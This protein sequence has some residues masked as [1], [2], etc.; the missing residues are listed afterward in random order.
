MTKGIVIFTSGEGGGV[1]KTG[2][3]SLENLRSPLT[4]VLKFYVPPLTKN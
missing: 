3:D 2:K 1:V 4:A